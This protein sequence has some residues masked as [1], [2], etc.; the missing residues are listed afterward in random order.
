MRNIGKEMKLNSK[1][2]GLSQ[3]PLKNCNTT[4]SFCRTQVNKVVR[5]K[6]YDISVN[7]FFNYWLIIIII[8]V[9]VCNPACILFPFFFPLW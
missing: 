2:Q 1:M 9:C 4:F 7:E 6:H 3:E 8:C 5:C